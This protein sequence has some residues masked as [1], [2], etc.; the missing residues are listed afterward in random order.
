MWFIWT[1]SIRHYEMGLEH[2]K[3]YE[4]LTVQHSQ[5]SPIF[6][7]WPLKAEYNGLSF[8]SGCRNKWQYSRAKRVHRLYTSQI[9]HCHATCFGLDGYYQEDPSRWGKNVGWGC[10]RIGTPLDEWSASRRDLN[11]T[12]HN[13]HNRIGMR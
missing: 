2:N 3:S 8:L 6:Q 1:H 9:C 4:T 5:H 10:L 12:T 7:A 11:L 13:T